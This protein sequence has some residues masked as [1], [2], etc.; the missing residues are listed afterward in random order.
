MTPS[1]FGIFQEVEGV[2]KD[3]RVVNLSLL[4]TPWY[5]EQLKNKAPKINFNLKDENIAK[6]DPVLVRHTP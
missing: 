2:R 3:V 6:L 1:R 5:I 4:N